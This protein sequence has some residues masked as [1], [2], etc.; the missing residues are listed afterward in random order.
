M[1]DETANE[2]ET[3]QEDTPI[4]WLDYIGRPIQFVSV[5]VAEN[6]ALTTDGADGTVTGILDSVVDNGEYI[7]FIIGGK[8]YR[9]EYGTPFSAR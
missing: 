2:V 9:A 7:R 4:N 3:P 1:T 5:A 8:T 6:G